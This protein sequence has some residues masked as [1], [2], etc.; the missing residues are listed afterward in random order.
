MPDRLAIAQVTPFAWEAN[1]E[2]NEYVA[3]VSDELVQRGHSVLVVAPTESAGDLWPKG[4]EAR[5]A[6]EPARALG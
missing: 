5:R 6:G 3:R 1:N 2:V 4:P